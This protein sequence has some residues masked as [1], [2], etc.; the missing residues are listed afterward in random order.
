MEWKKN[1]SEIINLKDRRRTR[2]RWGLCIRWCDEDE[3]DDD[4]E[5]IY[6]WN[7][8]VAYNEG[9]NHGVKKNM[10]LTAQLLNILRSLFIAY[11]CNWHLNVLF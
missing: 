2:T 11:N 8:Y 7:M 1:A 4:D 5:G 10:S 9:Y 3:D 6:W